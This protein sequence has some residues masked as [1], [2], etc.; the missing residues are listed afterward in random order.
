[1][2]ALGLENQGCHIGKLRYEEVRADPTHEGWIKEL[3]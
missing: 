1:M 3:D 2:L